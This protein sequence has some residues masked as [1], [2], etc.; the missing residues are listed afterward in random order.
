MHCGACGARRAGRDEAAQLQPFAAPL[1]ALQ[2]AMPSLCRSAS[3]AWS[4]RLRSGR[5]SR[6]WGSTTPISRKCCSR[7][8]APCC[9]VFEA[10]GV[11][12]E[13]RQQQGVGVQAVCLAARILLG[14]CQPNPFCEGGPA[15]LSETVLLPLVPPWQGK[16]SRAQFTNWLCYE[17]SG[18]C[19]HKPPP[20][21]KVGLQGRC[22]LAPGATHQGSRANY[23]P[24]QLFGACRTHAYSAM[25]LTLPG[26]TY[27]YA[28]WHRP[29][30]AIHLH[31][32][33][34]DRAPG[35]AFQPQR[36]GEQNLERMV[37]EMQVNAPAF[38]RS[39]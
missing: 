4:A 32:L 14:R 16:K 39:V 19:R 3:A 23:G 6:S 29:I 24:V 35:P 1:P 34:Q 22:Q 18:A 21:P 38:A 7:C 11:G 15:S 8:A 27:M 33:P 17:L 26:R 37:G 5:Q 10:W 20:L 12:S 30:I 28:A 25:L 31:P 2:A 36:E 9:P 13:G